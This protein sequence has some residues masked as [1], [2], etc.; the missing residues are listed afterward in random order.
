VHQIAA[1]QFY[2]LIAP[3]GAVL[4]YPMLVIGK[5]ASQDATV[6]TIALASGL[7]L[8]L[9]LDRARQAVENLINPQ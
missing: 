6:A 3:L 5:A 1:N 2:V 8:N 9:L 4:I 7:G